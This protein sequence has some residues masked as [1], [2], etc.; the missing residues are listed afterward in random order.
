MHL[1]RFGWKAS[2]AS[3]VHQVAEALDFDM[4]VT[5]S[6]FPKHDCGPSQ[7]SCLAADTAKP[8]LPRRI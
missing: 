8:E 2:K 3:V 7:A 6:V 1:G 5:T 4:G